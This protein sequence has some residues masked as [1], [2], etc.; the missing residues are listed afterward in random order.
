M[1]EIITTTGTQTGSSAPW[2]VQEPYL[3]AGFERAKELFETPIRYGPNRVAGMGQSTTDALTRIIGSSINNPYLNAATDYFNQSVGGGFLPMPRTQQSGMMAPGSSTADGTYGV[4]PIRSDQPPMGTYTSPG[5]ATPAPNMTTG[6]M[7]STAPTTPQLQQMNTTNPYLDAMYAAAAA[8]AT[9]EFTEN[10]LPGLGSQF[11]MSGR[12]GSPGMMNAIQSAATGY[13]E[14]LGTLAATLYGQAYENERGRQQEMAMYAPQLLNANLGLDTAALEAGQ[15]FDEQSQRELTDRVAR[16]QFNQEEPW[17][18]TERYMANISGPYGGT[19]N[20]TTTQ[21]QP[22]FEPELWQQIL[23]GIGA[24][25]GSGA[26][27]T[28]ATDA[29]GNPIDGWLP[30]LLAGTSDTVEGAWDWF[31]RLFN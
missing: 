9:R 13:G 15:T 24:L 29:Q 19:T 17:K 18:R 25:G 5:A 31:N 6:G 27:G 21:E 26:F 12:S 3:T 4:P 30:G 2:G 22:V 14:G 28:G 1:A 23:G 7:P 10:V 16:F 11:G 20:S 8:P